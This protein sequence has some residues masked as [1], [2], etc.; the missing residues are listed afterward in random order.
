MESK[1]DTDNDD[2]NND[3]GIKWDETKIDNFKQKMH[4]EIV[5]KIDHLEQDNSQNI[6][7]VAHSLTEILQNVLKEVSVTKTSNSHKKVNQNRKPRFYEE[8]FNAR[9]CFK[10]A[11]NTYMKTGNSTNRD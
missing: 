10:M 9:N 4:D 6:E 8:Y 5:Y 7:Q 3:V 11:R 1:D 2:N